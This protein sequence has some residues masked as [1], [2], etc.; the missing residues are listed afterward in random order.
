[1]FNKIFKA[2]NPDTLNDNFFKVIHRDWMLITAGTM[3][4]FNTM[5]A[6]WGATGILWNKKIAICFIRPVRYTFEF[7]EKSNLY[8]LSFFD[9][10]H[11]DAL[12]F[13]GSN[14]G[15]NVDKMA[16]TGLK[17]IETP[18]GSITFAQ[19]RLVFEC[20][21]LYS[22]YIKEEFFSEKNLIGLHYPH[23]DFHKFYIGEI[24]GCFQ[25]HI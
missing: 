23:K 2:V 7:A 11:Q 22:D 14:S 20:R 4:S 5:T 19:S 17:P 15:R 9:D 3:N 10:E 1:M 6:S 24:T 18:E 16:K 12:N 21:K 8:T 13:C 25:R